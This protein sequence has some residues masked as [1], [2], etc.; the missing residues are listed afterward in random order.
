MGDKNPTPKIEDHYLGPLPYFESL[1]LSCVS[2]NRHKFTI[3]ENEIEIKLKAKKPVKITT[4]MINVSDDGKN[5]SEYIFTQRKGEIIYFMI[6]FPE[7][8]IYKFEVYALSAN[9]K[10]KAMHNVFGYLITVDQATKTVH[11]F[12]KQYTQWD[13]G[14]F[15]YK[16]LVLDSTSYLENVDFKVYIPNAKQVAVVV[17]CNEWHPLELK[18][19]NFEGSVTL[20]ST[21]DNVRISANYDESTTYATLLEYIISDAEKTDDPWP[22]VEGNY[23]GSLG[24]FTKF[25]FV[26]DSHKTE[27]FST[28]KNECEIKMKTKK[29]VR[30][31][32]LLIDCADQS[33]EMSHCVFTQR[34]DDT[35]FYNIIFPKSGFYKFEIFALPASDESKSLINVFN[36]L[37]KATGE[38]KEGYGYPKQY[39]QWEG[40]CYLYEPLVLNSSSDLKNV[41]FKVHIPKAKAVAIIVDGKEW[42]YL[43]LKGENFEGTVDLEACRHKGVGVMLDANFGEESD[44]YQRLLEYK[45]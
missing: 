6:N 26:T 20:R 36:Y 32:A 45:I 42:H 16:P 3:L 43:E 8:G 24:N 12:P 44:T 17:N 22:L 31:K 27:K 40:G 4:Q 7:C 29:D 34:K 14:C 5:V 13:D 33:K 28:S 23:L 11:E 2:H 9:D 39:T 21:D 35:I 30:T 37:I 1:G 19:E 41:S 25:G 38:T 10:H 18:G 15:L